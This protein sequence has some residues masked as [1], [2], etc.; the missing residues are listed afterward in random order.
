VENWVRT[1]DRIVGTDDVKL[2]RLLREAKKVGQ[3]HR[4]DLLGS[5]SEP[6]KSVAHTE[7]TDYTAARP[8]RASVR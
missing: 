7:T 4:S 5:E 8:P 3:G 2:L 1:G 6:S